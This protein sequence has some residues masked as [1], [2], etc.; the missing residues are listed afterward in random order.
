MDPRSKPFTRYLPD[1]L[2][3]STYAP[4]LLLISYVESS[5]VKFVGIDHVTSAVV[6]EGNVTAKLCGAVA[7]TAAFTV[8]VNINEAV[9]AVGVAESVTLYVTLVVLMACVGAT[10]TTRVFALN[11]KP[12]GKFIVL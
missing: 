1:L 11:V 10:V 6:A 4:P 9:L 5:P 8:I 12:L 7:V 2:F 3:V